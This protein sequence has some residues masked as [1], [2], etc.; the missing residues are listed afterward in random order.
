MTTPLSLLIV[1]FNCIT[2]INA[3][4]YF[5]TTGLMQRNATYFFDLSLLTLTP[6]PALLSPKYGYACSRMRD[7]LQSTY[8]KIVIAG[9]IGSVLYNWLNV[10][11]ILDLNTLKWTTGPSL[12]LGLRFLQLTEHYNGGVVAI[13]GEDSFNVSRSELFYLQP[14]AGAWQT[15]T[16][17]LSTGRNIANVCLL[18]KSLANCNP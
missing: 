6:G 7:S 12:P 5:V 2:A 13:G 10:V 1:D 11:E 3:T 4:T 16:Q 17:R 18:H 14:G 15:M 8:N 9:G